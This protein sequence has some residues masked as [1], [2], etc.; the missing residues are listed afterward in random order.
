MYLSRQIVPET[1]SAP[2]TKPEPQVSMTPA[3]AERLSQIKQRAGWIPP[4]YQVQLAK[5]NATDQAVD[6][7][8]NMKAKQIVDDQASEEEGGWW[9]RNVYDR[10]KAGTR[11]GFA[12]L[13]FV[14]EFVQG[15]LAQIVD[16]DNSVDGWFISSTLGSMI[17][18]PELQG[19]GFFADE[20]LMEKQA[21]RARRY[22]GTVNGSAWTVGRGAANVVFKANSKPYNIMSGILDAVAMVKFDPTGPVTKGLKYVTKGKNTVPLFADE[23]TR[24]LREALESQ[25]GVTRGLAEATLDGTK[26]DAFTRTNGR[27][28]RLVDRLTEIKNPVR[29]AEIFDYNLPNEMI[30]ALADATDPDVVRAVL[31]AG[32]TVRGGT[33]LPQDIRLI[34]G[35]RVVSGVGDFIVERA[36]FIDG[37]RKSRF[38]TSMGDAKIVTHGTQEDNRNAVKSIVSYLR[39]AGVDNDTVDSVA[40]LAFRSFTP[41]AS[42]VARKQTM[43]AFYQTL[44][45]V[46]RVDGIPEQSIDELFNVGRR[47]MDQ[48]RRYLQ[49]RLGMPFDNGYK[50]YLMNKDREF[51]PVED[52]ERI[53]KEL[54]LEKGGKSAITSPTELVELL[55]RAIVLPDLREVRR[56]TRSKLFRDV[57]GERMGKLPITAKRQT[58]MVEVI[59]DEKRF[60]EVTREINDLLELPNPVDADYVKLEE[61]QKELASLKAM[62]P[63]KIITPD[64]RF[65]LMAIDYVQNQLWKPLA[66]ATGGYVVRNSLDAQVRM[67]FSEL[68]SLFTHPFEYINLVLG[69]SKKMT[70]RMENLAKVRRAAKPGEVLPEGVLTLDDLRED[71]R[72]AMTFGMRQMGFGPSAFENHL[73]ATGSFDNVN[74]GMSNGL[75]LHTDAVVQNGRRTQGDPLRKLATQTFVEMGGVNKTSIDIAANRVANVIMKNP[76]IRRQIDD[77]HKFG[78]E[79]TATETGRKV[80]TP[81]ID[82]TVLPEDEQIAAYRQYAYRIVVGNSQ[83]LTGA[84]P[85]A[86][87]MY[88]F[89]YVPKTS[90]GKMVGAFEQS[91]DELTVLERPQAG[92][93]GATVQMSDDQIGVVTRVSDLSG[94]FVVDPF[95]GSVVELKGLVATVQPVFPD[96]AFDATYGSRDA[97]KLIELMPVSDDA[98]RPG[99]PMVLKRELLMR[100]ERFPGRWD[101]LLDGMNVGTD[102]FFNRLVGYTSRKLER[103]PVFREYYYQQVTDLAG[104]LKPEDAQRF[105]DDATAKAKKAGVSIQDYVGDKQMVGVL[106]KSAETAGDISLEEL[107][108]YAKFVALTRTKELLYDASNRS[109]LEDVLR[110]IMP[111]APAWKEIMGTYV[112]FMRANPVNT[113]RS[114]Q[115]I[116]T[117]LQGADPDNDGR[118][119]F[120]QDPNTNQMMFTFPASGTLAKVLTGLDAPLEAPVKRLSQGIQAFP[121]LGPMGQV[122]ASKILPHLPEAEFFT[123]LLLPYGLKGPAT[124]FNPTPQWLQKA[125]Q[126]FTAPTADL[127]T[128]YANTYIETMRALSASGDYDLSSKDDINQLESDAKFKAR[129]LMGF[130]A[131]SQFFGPTA[132]ATEFK[133]PTEQGD[134]FVSGLIKEFY[135]MQANPDIGYEK[136]VPEFLR[137][138]G[139]EAAL[140]VASK[141]RS[142][143]EGLEATKEFQDWADANAGLVKDYASVANYLAPAGSD[144]N[145]A[146]WSLQLQRGER[147]RLTDREVVEL[148]QQ[149]IGSAKYRDARRQVGP[150][151]SDAARDALKQYREYLHGKYPGFP[152]VAEFEVGSFYNDIL[153]LKDLVDD[154]RSAGNDTA[155]AI[156]EYLIARERAI[157]VS[158]VSEQGFK[159]ARS[160]A[161]AR[162]GLE[163]IGISLAEK[164][165]GFSRIFDRLLASEV[166]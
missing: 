72:E 130:R 18:N 162:A 69:S 114:F 93:V 104:R 157:A 8:A 48:M 127:E 98:A 5:S 36:P 42:D 135:D 111:F 41:G 129:I 91:V 68:P 56:F 74:R 29:I 160:A 23:A 88:A 64:Q 139:D 137:I 115:R 9:R 32:W 84:I 11:W 151:P 134:R 55:D 166:E 39:T 63:R 165:P 148:A 99:L 132:G 108:D 96:K 22:R 95:D 158:G 28:V 81:A 21:E 14:P 87:F 155:V 119:F 77:L 153:S 17:E 45:S 33:A 136:A 141:T 102:W 20:K 152:A 161:R 58:R 66:L 140:Y 125:T 46:M 4:D 159:T 144:F 82:L 131:L 49:D 145:F 156:R 90:A 80:R 146:V 71:V 117:G 13:N 38:F 2:A 143:A 107:D 92:F 149:R 163:S 126:V 138:Y 10:L 7:V 100:D 121:A 16:E 73:V 24:A 54:G 86:E 37:I 118:G 150:Y 76:A 106:R 15:G 59:T 154:P 52:I 105:L 89:G 30:T 31:G 142:V 19:E 6:A 123:G 60:D 109:N 25:A 147:V 57:I 103:S 78:F 122:A 110:V 113:A 53:I 27:M 44:K 34:Q 50:S 101:N 3:Q 35:N 133:I 1:K 65:G 164:Y 67:A 94:E 120:Y 61:L 75:A 12:G 116:Y 26:F 70:L 112:G 40:N 79:I 97:R 62:E 128:Q 47:R 85:E 83:I 43:D 124:A 51:L